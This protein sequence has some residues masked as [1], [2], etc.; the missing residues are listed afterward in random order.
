[1]PTLFAVLRTGDGVS[2]CLL[3][4]AATREVEQALGLGHPGVRAASRRAESVFASLSPEERERVRPR[5]WPSG[6]REGPWCCITSCNLISCCLLILHMLHQTWQGLQEACTTPMHLSLTDS[7][8]VC[9]YAALQVA[10]ARREKAVVQ[11]VV[12]AFG[13]VRELGEVRSRAAAWDD[14]SL[15]ALPRLA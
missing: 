3:L 2:A 8:H 15:E 6:C 13:Q 14:M 12:E 10:A 11:R 1:M 4:E 9:A 7:Q 5:S